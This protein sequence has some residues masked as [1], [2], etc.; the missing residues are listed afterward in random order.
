MIII[1]K[2]I[3]EYVES[4]VNESPPDPS[5]PSFD[6]HFDSPTVELQVDANKREYVES[7][8]NDSPPDPSI[9]SFDLH[10]D[11]PTVEL[12]VD[13]DK[14]YEWVMDE[15]ENEEETI[16]SLHG[17]K[18]V[19]LKRT[20]VRTL[21]PRQQ[22]DNLVVNYFGFLLND[23]E[24]DR[25]KKDVFC[26]YSDPFLLDFYKD[27]ELKI[28]KGEKNTAKDPKHFRYNPPNFDKLKLQGKK[29]VFLPFCFKEHWSLFAMDVPNN[30]FYILDSLHGHTVFPNIITYAEE[31]GEI[32]KSLIWEMLFAP[33][34]TEKLNILKKC[35]YYKVRGKRKP[36]G[37]EALRTPEV[38]KPEARVLRERKPAASQ[39]TPYATIGT[40]T[41]EKVIARQNRPKLQSR[42]GGKS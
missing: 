18:N 3:G 14:L 42:R 20:N 15:L 22:I 33:Q 10:F 16:A 6:L 17:K 23:S 9:P 36:K 35:E 4:E 25:F 2:H 29:L 19:F 26:L 7:E 39:M 41:L 21:R 37:R 34:N 24:K 11:S 32:R 5:I 30:K 28:I 38:T 8:V 12:W 1:S 13:V 27:G 31:C 40:K